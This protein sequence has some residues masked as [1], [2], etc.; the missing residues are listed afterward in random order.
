MLQCV[1]EAKSLLLEAEP[2]HGATSAI[3]NF[4]L[5]CHHSLLGEMDIGIAEFRLQAGPSTPPVAV[6]EFR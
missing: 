6:R 4:N 3:L 2:R 5:A 1:A